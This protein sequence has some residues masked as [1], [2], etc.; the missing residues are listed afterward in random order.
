M[1]FY[2][3]FFVQG[4]LASLQ[5][6]GL[7]ANRIGDDGLKALAEACRAGGALASCQ[8][9]V[10]ESNLIGDTGMKA[11]ADA[12]AMGALP[13]LEAVTLWGNPGNEELVQAVL[14]ERERRK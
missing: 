3:R 4:A 13:Q 10:L 6:L 2:A 11:L 8:T 5:T 14:R 12:C 9:L 1:S 7:S